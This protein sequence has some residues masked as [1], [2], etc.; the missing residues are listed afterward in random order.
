LQS[1]VRIL[2]RRRWAALIVCV[3]VVATVA[4]GTYV[5]TPVYRATAKVLIDPEVPRSS[6]LQENNSST[7]V[8]AD[9]QPTQYELIRLRPVIERVIETLN[10]KERMPGLA[11]SRE[12]VE[13]VLTYVTIEPRRN[14]RLVGIS[15][16]HADP[17]LA[18]DAANGIA[19]SYIRFNLDTK[20][21]ASRDAEEWLSE[22][23]AKLKSYA[24]ASAAELQKYRVGQG[25][26]GTQEQPQVTSQRL[27]E[28][29]RAYLES[30]GQ[31][32]A[33]ES[34]LRELTQLAHDKSGAQTMFTV[35][36]TP[37]IQKLR[38]DL[39]NLEAERTKIRQQYS[40]EYPDVREIDA[41]IRQAQERL[42]REL[43]GLIRALET[44]QKVARAREQ[45]LLGN[46]QALQ[47]ETYSFKDKEI[48][49][50][51]LSR[52]VESS[53]QLYEMVFRRLKE[54]GVAGGIGTNTVRIVEDARV[55]M[56]PHRPRK[57]LNLALGIV[58]GLLAGVGAA[59][60][61]DHFDRT[62]KT[63]DDVRRRLG[64]PVMGLVPMR[65]SA[66]AGRRAVAKFPIVE[67]A[68]CPSVE[69]EPGAFTVESYRKLRATLMSSVLKKGP[70]ILLVA[71]AHRREGKT[72]TAANL[73]VTLATAGLRVCIVDADLRRPRM[74]VLFGALNAAGLTS[75]L[76]EERDL[77]EVAGD[78]PIA[79]VDLVA[80]GPRAPNPPDLLASERMEHLLESVSTTHDVVI[81]DSPSLLAVSDAL[82]LASKADG[83]I[84]VVRAWV[85][86]QDAALQAVEQIEGV[87]GKL[88]GVVLNAV[89]FKR[90]RYY[91]RAY[92]SSSV[93]SE[94]D[95]DLMVVP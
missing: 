73:G 60:T 77:K 50:L 39:T 47:R 40:A 68:K 32:I 1:Y 48:Q 65:R 79:G 2:R 58:V 72:T 69:I 78:T 49:Q 62:I 37:L 93:Y 44:E 11:A 92:I 19:E 21:R 61:I 4:I 17:R 3:V 30:Q 64:L 15:V 86:P 82:A 35:A 25:M 51:A 5:Q 9:F 88:L 13:R 8:Q 75:A 10:L 23:L 84:L 76:V 66:H 91:D 6:T 16:D 33:I 54:T 56:H 52:Q 38:I 34:K 14:T 70:Q 26:L 71:S 57:A 29:N 24:E 31:R 85:T 95:G 22:Q 43:Q 18:A 83:V 89:D 74:H 90:D 20:L 67:V 27:T 42:D 59:L 41:Q 45:T 12:P 46:L 53:Q 94:S 36:D 55:P 7:N 63:P 80:S 81:V 28:V 87:S